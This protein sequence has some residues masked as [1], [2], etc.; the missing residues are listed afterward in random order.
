MNAD[1]METLE[2]LVSSDASLRVLGSDVD[3]LWEGPGQFLN[4]RQTQSVEKPDFRMVTEKVE[5]FEDGDFGWVM[6][7]STM[8][9]PEATTRI[10]HTA[11]LRL[12]AGSWRVIQW[13]NSVPVPNQQIFGV[14]LTTTLDYLVASVLDSED[15]F[16]SVTGSE[17][18]MT[19]VFTDIV[20]STGLAESAGD[21]TWAEIIGAHESAIRRITASQ[22][23]TVVK[24]LGDGSMLA[25]ESARAAVRAAVEIQ[26]ASAQSFAIRIGI[27][28]GEVIRTVDDLRGLTVN[29]A[30]RIAA[31]AS[32]GGIMASSTTR[33][34]V[35]SMKGIQI[36]EPKVI[37]LEGLSDTHQIVPLEWDSQ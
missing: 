18:T 7:F 3:E 27:H 1:D 29:K 11:V 17:G 8:V 2:N 22:G 9:T 4:V 31:A 21:I 19:L 10:R 28:T 6:L 26:R 33:D 24:F 36:G 16:A 34:L 23:G 35:G 30:A 15:Q 14:E 13:H 20:D 5:A 12:E 37:V 32:A 25:F